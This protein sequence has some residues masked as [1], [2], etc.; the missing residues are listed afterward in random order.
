MDWLQGCS[1]LD[2]VLIGISLFLVL[3]GF[4][5]GCSGQIGSLAGLFLAA[6]IL[7]SGRPL[8]ISQLTRF[9]SFQE[10]SLPFQ[11]LLLAVMTVICVSVWLLAR[12]LISR[13]IKTAVPQPMD[14]VLGG[15]VGAVEVGLLI[16]ILCA[17][18]MFG[19]EKQ[20]AGAHK[21]FLRKH[22]ALIDSVS[23]WIAPF[24]GRSEAGRESPHASRKD[25]PSLARPNEF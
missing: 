21:P 19:P 24:V 17:M 20:Q 3:R 13:I 8:V 25:G 4:F 11:I 22:S 23:P 2:Y 9:S 14:A 5:T 7:F 6:V 12:A 16:S 1:F 15:I 18:G 10:N